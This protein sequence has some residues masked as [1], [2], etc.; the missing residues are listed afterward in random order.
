MAVP[1][2]KRH[3]D[4][5]AQLHLLSSRGLACG[6]SRDAK[7]SLHDIGYY[8]LAAYLYP[9]RELL[10]IGTPRETK[11]QYRGDQFMESASLADAVLL[12]KFDEKLRT[13]LFQGLSQLEL[14]LRFQ[15]VHVLG[16]RGPFAH[17][18]VEHLDQKA[19]NSP[20]P[21]KFADKYETKFDHWLG[22]YDSLIRRASG[23]D[24]IQHFISKYDSEIAIWVAVE[25]FDFGAL[26]RLFSL[27]NRRDQNL[28]AKRFGVSDGRIFQSWLQGLNVVR[29]HCAHHNRLW[30][31]QIISELAQ[32]PK[33]VV[34]ANIQHLS[35]VVD[36]RKIYGWA[37]VLAY[38]MRSYDPSSNWHRSFK[39]VL[40]KFPT[41]LLHTPSNAMGFPKSWTTLPLWTE[42]P[43]Q[44]VLTTP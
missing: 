28:I 16:K 20:P 34:G 29:N 14:S 9:Y 4:L 27:L 31:R 39:T 37:A 30:N 42:A 18:E 6:S 1:Y 12:A 41:V 2:T 7:Q 32:I 3:L 10:P 5:T 21:K 19:C 15:I 13:T 44:S 26:T 17:L 40:G 24:Y 8:R 43:G 25:T 36:R 35:E 22:A 33:P 38:S 11:W 23:E